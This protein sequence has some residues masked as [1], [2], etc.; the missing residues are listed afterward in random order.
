[1]LYTLGY[2]RDLVSPYVLTGGSCPSAEIVKSRVNES[3]R[4]LLSEGRTDWDQTQRRVRLSVSNCLVTLP[5]EF[6]AA[7]LA[8]IDK[9]PAD[10]FQ[11]SYQYLE[12]GP[13]I[14]GP[15]EHYGN[16]LMDEGDG[17]PTF[18]DIPD[19]ETSPSYHLFAASARKED[20]DK[21]IFVT[22]T[23][24]SG[25]HLLQESGFPGLNLPVSFWTG[26]KEGV[27]NGYPEKISPVPVRSISGVTLPPGR[28]GYVSLYAYDPKTHAMFFLSKYHP[29]EVTPGYRRYRLLS[30]SSKNARTVDLL[31]K[32]R[33]LPASRDEDVLLI[34][35]PDAIKTMVM[36]IREENAGN[37]QV[38][39]LLEEKANA[40]LSRELVNKR[41]GEP[42]L[43]I[44]D[45]FTFGSS[46]NI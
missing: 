30:D 44:H 14:E 13:W 15:G 20:E 31:C 4:R 46:L 6:Q 29:D 12:S 9:G 34:Q 39:M 3:I 23:G 41:S 2:V 18:F 1:M 5:R 26:G 21:T 16:D 35:N 33:Y 25:D 17:W 19:C 8:A 43:R 38:A 11:N 36:A 22:G 37:V 24:V 28:K 27:L 45:Q 40:Q 32:V 7:R 42:I 10:L